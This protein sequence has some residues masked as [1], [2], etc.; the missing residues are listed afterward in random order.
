MRSEQFGTGIPSYHSSVDFF[1]SLSPFSLSPSPHLYISLPISI[2]LAISIFLAIS[3]FLHYTENK[4]IQNRGEQFAEFCLFMRTSPKNCALLSRNG[5]TEKLKD[6]GRHIVRDL[7]Q[8]YATFPFP[9]IFIT[10]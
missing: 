2:S 9:L 10:H 4:I 3:S 5:N 6:K 7:Y 8:N 1:V